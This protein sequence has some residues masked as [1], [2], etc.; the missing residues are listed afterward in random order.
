MM[1]REITIEDLQEQYRDYAE[2]IGVENA[3]KLSNF[4]G[5]SHICI[6]KLENLLKAGRYKNI[7]EEYDG[8]NIKQLA[9]K[10]G[11]SERTVYRLLE[12]KIKIKKSK[13]LPGQMSIFDLES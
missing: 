2:V 7:I 5:G 11:V 10:Y 3:V 13:V 9:V 1:E 8:T 6:P 4:L 12:G